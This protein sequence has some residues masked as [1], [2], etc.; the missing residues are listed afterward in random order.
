[1]RKLYFGLSGDDVKKLQMKLQSLGYA[2]FVPTSF[3]GLKTHKAVREYQK[4]MNL[5]STGV[6]GLTEANLLGLN[7]P[8]SRGEKFFNTAMTFL[9]KDA[10]PKDVVNDDVACAETVD[11]IYKTAFGEYMN[12]N[13]I[14][15]STMKMLDVLRSQPHKF[16]QIFK[17]QKG[18]ILLYPSGY[19]NGNL[20]NGHV[21]I[22]G[23]NDLLY[24]NT[25]AN[26]KFEQNYTT[27]TARYRYEKIGGY[28]RYYFMLM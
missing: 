1:M 10:T 26:G 23:D 20:S 19:G 9:G 6:I 16:A 22:C 24:S 7:D 17:P 13:T 3:F 21:F 12:G 14:T 8:I 28:P 11:T 27:A 15:I 4:S 5:P 25:S 2:T 18:A